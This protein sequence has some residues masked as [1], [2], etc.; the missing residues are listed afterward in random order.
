MKSSK[1]QAPNT[2]EAPSSKPQ[3]GCAAFERLCRYGQILHRD[4]HLDFGV[5]DFF[6]T[7]SLELGAF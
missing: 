3:D 7:W 2:K 1:Y 5:W 4:Y 6:G